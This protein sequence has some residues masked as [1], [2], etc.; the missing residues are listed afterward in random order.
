MTFTQGRPTVFAH[1]GSSGTYAEHTR[2]AYMHALHEGAD[3]VETDVHLTAD[4]HVI[5][6]HNFTVD[7]ASD[8]TGEIARMTLAQLRAL[9][10]HSWK[11]QEI[12]AAY[13]TPGEQFVTLDELLAILRGA[14]RSVGLALELKHPDAPDQY[15]Q[16]LDDAAL[17]VLRSHGWES[18]TSQIPGDDAGTAVQVSFMSFSA[19]SLRNLLSSHSDIPWD[20]VCAVFDH[21]ERTLPL[22]EEGAVGLA[23]P[24]VGWARQHPE[25]LQQW[26]QRG[27]GSRIWTVN[28]AEDARFLMG[29]GAVEGL[30][31]DHPARIIPFRD[32]HVAA[33]NGGH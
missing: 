20:Q 23:G 16:E 2:A 32:E 9:D 8:G 15:R 3:G 26:G 22:V 24:G 29:L 11:G 12:P 17:E 31:T 7:A 5:C 19:E 28:T 14:G 1:R 4:G 6:C 33:A 21:A 25:R 10:F 13:G 30:T 18:S 27:I